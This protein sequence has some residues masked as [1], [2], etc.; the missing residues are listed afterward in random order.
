MSNYELLDFKIMGDERGSL[1]ALEENHNVPFD[2]KRVYYI[3]GTKTD[4]HRG[5]HAHRNLR[6]LAI[7]VCG[8]CKFLLDNGQEQ[9]HIELNT[10]T[11]GLLIEGI[12]WREMYDFSDDCVLMV[13]ADNYYS[14]NDYIRHY[15][16]FLKE[17]SHDS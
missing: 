1:I 9:M 10:P 16:D 7:C 17:V 4:V 12:M 8:S 15:E 13:L 14:E 11:Q 6:Q 2:V 3:F 5:K